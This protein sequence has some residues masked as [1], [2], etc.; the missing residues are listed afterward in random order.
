M[1]GFGLRGAIVLAAA[2]AAAIIGFLSKQHP[3]TIVEIRSDVAPIEP[4]LVEI[5]EGTFKMGNPTGTP[6][7]KPVR[8]IHVSAFSIGKFEVT[9]EEY[10]RFC[11]ATGRPYPPD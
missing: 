8:D 1:R 10:R 11:D 2:V 3:I 4:T 6:S 5:P 9:N 7:E